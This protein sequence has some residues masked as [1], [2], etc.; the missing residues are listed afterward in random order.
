MRTSI[1]WPSGLLMVVLAASSVSARAQGSD[2]PRNLTVLP[3][4]LSRDSVVKLMRF[5]VA[6]GLGV[7][8]NF[9]HGAPGVS[10]DSIDFASDERET[11]RTARAMMRMVARINGELLPEIPGRSSPPIRVTCITCHRAAPRP[12]MLQDTLGSVLMRHG[13]DSMVAT[14]ERLKQRYFG[15]FPY[16]FGQASLNTLAAQLI[17]QKR[18]ADARRVLELN[19]REHP[20]AWD[21][22]YTLA[23]VLESLGER[24][25]AIAQYRKVLTLFPT[26]APSQRRLQ[27]LTGR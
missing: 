14:Y 19:I 4:D 20:A 27:A 8:C 15:R 24:D 16:D 22:V 17:D 26:H 6:S 3:A 10:F 11:K 21:P 2:R 1:A 25:L 23:Q 12:L 18:H 7:S 9:C 13:A 5:E